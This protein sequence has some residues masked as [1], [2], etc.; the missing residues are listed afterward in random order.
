MTTIGFPYKRKFSWARH[1]IYCGETATALDH[2]YPKALSQRL[3]LTRESVFRAL[4]RALVVVPT[5]T[6]CNSIAGATPFLS[7]LEKRKFIQKSLRKKLA[8]QL[9]VV[10]WDEE[11]IDELG[12]TLRT[13]IIAEQNAHIVAVSRVNFPR[14]YEL[15][16]RSL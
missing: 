7:P 8:K 16:I 2:V 13:K 9:K 5:C 12:K 15:A 3:D 10:V 4:K 6:Q 14:R 11:E 1:C